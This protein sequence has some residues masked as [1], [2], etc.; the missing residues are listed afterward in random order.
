MTT[1]FNSTCQPLPNQ[2]GSI[3]D[4]HCS[5]QGI[6]PVSSHLQPQLEKISLTC[7]S[8]ALPASYEPVTAFAT[9]LDIGQQEIYISC[10]L[11]VPITA[12]IV[13]VAKHHHRCH[14]RH[15]RASTVATMAKTTACL[16]T[17]SITC[18]TACPLFPSI[19][20]CPLPTV[21]PSAWL[22]VSSPVS[23]SL[24]LLPCVS[25]PVSPPLCLL[26]CVSSPES[27]PFVSLNSYSVEIKLIYTDYETVNEQ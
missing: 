23:P 8:T 11:P 2:Y 21:N 22:Y 3:L 1:S 20:A 4:W 24:C 25:S 9:L 5:R 6:A 18:T 15:D 10:S 19:T 12:G 7:T 13:P 27:L 16:P 14:R 26:P 17:S